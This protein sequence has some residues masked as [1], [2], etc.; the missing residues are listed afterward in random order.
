MLCFSDIESNSQDKPNI[1]NSSLPLLPN[2]RK[3]I[4]LYCFDLF[5]WDVMKW[6]KEKGLCSYQLYTWKS[7]SQCSTD[8][9]NFLLNNMFADVNEGCSLDFNRFWWGSSK[10]LHWLPEYP[11]YRTL[12]KYRKWMKAIDMWKKGVTPAKSLK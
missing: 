6:H 4:T 2:K 3:C 12:N 10:L 9:W 5:Q 1:S 11:L 7:L 8:I